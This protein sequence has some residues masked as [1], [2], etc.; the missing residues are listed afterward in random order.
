[1]AIALGILSRVKKSRAGD[2]RKYSMTA[3]KK[4]KKTG[5]ASF[6]NRPKRKTTMITRQ[7]VTTLFPF[8]AALNWNYYIL[9]VL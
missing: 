3:R 7:A 4:G 6:N 1:M 2:I 9:N 8:M 5:L